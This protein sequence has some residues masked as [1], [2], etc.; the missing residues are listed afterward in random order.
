MNRRPK[1]QELVSEINIA[2]FTDVILVLLIIFMVMTPLISQSHITVHLPTAKSG[3]PA[4][5]TAQERAEIAITREGAVYLDGKP[6]TREKLNEAVAF[7]HR[8][9]PNL[10]VVVHSDKSVKFQ[11]IVE[12][13]DVLAGLG[14]TKLHIAATKDQQ[15]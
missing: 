3:T 12:V 8:N 7:L 1:K 14:I 10:S 2:P 6:V 15:E 13:L 5:K 11:E 9:N 4:E